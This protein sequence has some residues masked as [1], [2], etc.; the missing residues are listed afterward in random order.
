MF[1]ACGGSIDI[2]RTHDD[3]GTQISLLFGKDMWRQFFA[4]NTRKLVELAHKRNALF[5][6]HSCGAIEPLIE[7]FISCGVDILEP[8]Q[9]VKGL[10]PENL[11]NKYGGRIAFHGGI[12]TQGVLP[13]GTPEEV[14]EETRRYINALGKSGGYILM[15]SQSF[16][17]DVPTANIEAVYET[18]R[19]V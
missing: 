10:E 13:N 6:Q 17:N 14:R 16:E 15:A 18:D 4:K 19:T 5:Q 1:A 9:K 2:L 3:Y 8:L 12:D 7:G 11:Q